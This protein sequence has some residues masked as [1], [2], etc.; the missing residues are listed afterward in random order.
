MK[1]NE[2]YEPCK[3]IDDGNSCVRL[4]GHKGDFLTLL[5]C[6]VSEDGEVVSVDLAK[7]SGEVLYCGV[8]IDLVNVFVDQL[9]LEEIDPPQHG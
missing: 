2:L 1:A 9:G 4:R 7:P 3:I 5:P 8:P 6:G